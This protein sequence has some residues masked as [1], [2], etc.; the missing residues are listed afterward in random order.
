MTDIQSEH[1]ISYRDARIAAPALET[2]SK[3]GSRDGKTVERLVRMLSFCRKAHKLEKEGHELLLKQHAVTEKVDGEDQVV[4]MDVDTPD[5]R[6]QKAVVKNELSFQKACEN[7]S[8]QVAGVTGRA[9][10]PFTFADLGPGGKF[11]GDGL[12]AATIEAFGPF[13]EMGEPAEDM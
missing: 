11:K 9:P 3:V 4:V 1:T 5:G 2:A 8:M 7:F 13:V 6:G 10:K 12:D